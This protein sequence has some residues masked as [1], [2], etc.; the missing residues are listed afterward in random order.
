MIPVVA[1]LLG[2]SIANIGDAGGSEQ[3]IER[4]TMRGT[5]PN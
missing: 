5:H 2:E 1:A 3:G 4:K